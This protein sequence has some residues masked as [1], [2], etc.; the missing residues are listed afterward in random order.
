[1]LMDLFTL[2][3]Q[4][5]GLPTDPPSN[6]QVPA[7]WNLVTRVET[8]IQLAT[9]QARMLWRLQDSSVVSSNQYYVGF[10]G[11]RSFLR[12]LSGS[13]RGLAGL[14]GKPQLCGAPPFHPHLWRYLRSLEPCAPAAACSWDQTI[15]GG[16]QRMQDSEQCVSWALCLHIGP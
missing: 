3:F 5:Q 15:P 16:S 8:A 11:I 7:F 14:T 9:M 6:L 4:L 2:G 13:N 10:R 1:M 12:M